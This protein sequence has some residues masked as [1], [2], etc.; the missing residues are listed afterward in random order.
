MTKRQSPLIADLSELE[1]Y[2]Q[3]ERRT[4]FSNGKQ[5]QTQQ[6]QAKFSQN[7]HVI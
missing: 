4:T 6:F 7:D 2:S 1:R 5:Q 3:K